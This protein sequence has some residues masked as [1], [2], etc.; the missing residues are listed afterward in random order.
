[1][2]RVKRVLGAL[3]LPDP[4]PAF[5]VRVD[6]IITKMTGNAYFQSVPNIAQILAAAQA[7]NDKLKLDQVADTNKVV[8]AAVARDTQLKD[9][10]QLVQGLLQIVQQ[11]ADADGSHAS[12]II[13]SAGMY[14]RVVTVRQ[15]ADFVVKQGAVSGEVAAKA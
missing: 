8:G 14:V 10:K 11:T 12:A 7:A 4:V 3:K 2:G 5:T 1:M 9:T 15:I 6:L 13:E